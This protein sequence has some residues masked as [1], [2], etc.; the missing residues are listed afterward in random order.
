MLNNTVEN[1][2]NRFRVHFYMQV[3]KEPEM[4]KNEE[5][6]LTSVEAFS[7][8]C[9]KALGKPTVA[10]F[11]RMMGISAPNAAYKVN[12]LIRKGYIEK[13]Q[14]QQDHREYYLCPTEKFDRYYAKS[15]EFMDNVVERCRKRFSK[16]DLEK[17]DEML[18]IITNDCMPELDPRNIRKTR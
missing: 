2:Y 15:Y 17:F 6:T 4:A 16:D 9:I 18:A 13:V 1:L 8:E 3:F 7:L 5:E 12:S 14:S 11:S 10:E